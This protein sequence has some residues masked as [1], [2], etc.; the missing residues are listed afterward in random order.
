MRELR[1][2]ETENGRA[3]FEEWKNKLD[4]SIQFRLTAYLNRLLIGAAKN[5]TKSLGD[6]VFEL[7]LNIGPGYRVYFGEDG[8]QIIL[9]LLGGDKQSQFRDIIKAKGYWR[10]YNETFKKI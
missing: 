6:G 9:L 7:K 4:R 8:E 2:Y 5:N 3:P 1:S 10:N